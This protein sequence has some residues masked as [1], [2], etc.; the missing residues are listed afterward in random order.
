MR[1]ITNGQLSIEQSVRN[2]A[3]KMRSILKDIAVDEEPSIRKYPRVAQLHGDAFRLL[4][5][6]ITKYAITLLEEEWQQLEHAISTKSDLGE[7][8]CSILLRF[9]LAC[10]HHLRRAYLSG[11]PIPKS[12]VHPRWW[13]HGP[14]VRYTNWQ[15][16]YPD[17]VATGSMSPE[18]TYSVEQLLG[19]LG[20]E[21]K[22]RFEHQILRS[23]VELEKIG[24]RHL[25]MQALP[26]G[27]P[28]P[29][30]RRQILQRKSHGK[31]NARGL[32]GAEIAERQLNAREKAEKK[33]REQQWQVPKEGESQG[34][35]TITLAVRSPERPP[36]VTSPSFLPASTAPPRLQREESP[37]ESP[38]EEEQE[39]EQEGE[40]EE[41]QEEEHLEQ[42]LEEE[43]H[44][45]GKRRR[46]GTVSYKEAREQ[47][48]I[49]SLGHS[50]L[51][52]HA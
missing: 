7:C 14:I 48:L 49:G 9:G 50:Q 51:Q 3:S 39:G 45:R 44:G 21:E 52:H 30:P 25:E 41:E 34:G 31:A 24:K 10:K 46:M 19:L 11:Q 1:Q 33:A 12:L 16:T 4:R 15:P 5:G 23:K 17:D 8:F 47:G 22:A 42:H 13:I 43:E 18:L 29:Q 20:P 37:E 36:R 32:T 38:E 40:Q 27:K 26:I 6:Q 2:L 35:T 28:D